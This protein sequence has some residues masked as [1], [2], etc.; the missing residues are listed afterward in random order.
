MV[1]VATTGMQE[2][3]IHIRKIL[4]VQAFLYGLFA[5]SFGSED[6]KKIKEAIKMYNNIIIEESKTD[7]HRDIRTF[8]KMMQDIATKKVAQKLYIWIQSWHENGLF[9]DSKLK[10]LSF[11][12]IKIDKQKARAITKEY[13]SYKYFD[14]R[15]NKVV[16]PETDI[17]YKV[18]YSLIKK[19][20]K[21]L[22]SKIKVL[23]EKQNQEG[24]K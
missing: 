18:E 14:R 22:I 15:I 19:D 23:E 13:W 24:K 9:M 11:L 17:F 20:D 16:K 21:W 3:M 1:V 7:R 8:V 12:K 5:F 4:I 10:K 6:I 2:G